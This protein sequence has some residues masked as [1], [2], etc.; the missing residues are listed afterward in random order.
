MGRITIFLA[1][2]LMLFPQ[3]AFA[4]C[5][6]Y[7]ARFRMWPFA[8]VT[9]GFVWVV[10]IVGIL[11]FLIRTAG[12][13]RTEYREDPLEILKRRYARGEISREEYEQMKKDLTG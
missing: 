6:Y 11:Y 2:S 13:R 7:G 10:L 4:L 5:S 12:E 1:L 3:N 8:G 9:M